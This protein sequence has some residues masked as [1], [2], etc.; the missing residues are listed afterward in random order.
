MKK[1]S[2]RDANVRGKR[3]LMRV[4]FNVPMTK[5]G[6]VADD[7]RLRASLP[8]IRHVVESGGSLVLMSHLGRPKGKAD[9]AFTLAPVAE[10]LQSLLPGVAVRFVAAS[11]GE[12]AKKA[13]AALRPG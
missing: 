7:E 3:V 12:E 5:D 11:V 13:A 2:L 6:K 8:S 9:P 10:R 4:D 1:M